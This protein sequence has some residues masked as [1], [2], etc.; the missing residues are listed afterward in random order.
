MLKLRT[1]L[2][3]QHAKELEELRACHA[4]KLA[5]LQEE[6]KILRAKL[7]L[8]TENLSRIRSNNVTVN[9]LG[10]LTPEVGLLLA[11]KITEE[12]FWGGQR[13]IG[14]AL[15][16]LRSDE[17]KP[18]YNVKDENRFKL[19]IRRGDEKV[20]DDRATKIIKN[21]EGPVKERIVEVKRELCERRQDPIECASVLDAAADC[22][23]FSNPKKNTPFL[24]S[25]SSNQGGA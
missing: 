16:D 11:K 21:V 22:L 13:E 4:N 3:A 12:I 5:E 2:E 14:L 7:D 10:E 18:F 17:D 24:K 9:C 15:R 8:Q 25:L 20:R 19:E 1:S 23:D 6:N